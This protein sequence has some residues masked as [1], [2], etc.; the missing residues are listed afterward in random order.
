M[1]GEPKFDGLSEREYADR[2]QESARHRWRS[3]ARAQFSAALDSDEDSLR[4]A[5]SLVSV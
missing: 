3:K 2:D 4:P 5:S 1:I